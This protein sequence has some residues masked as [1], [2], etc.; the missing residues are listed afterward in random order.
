MAIEEA[1]VIVLERPEQPRALI[2]RPPLEEGRRSTIPIV[3]DRHQRVEARPSR[4][5]PVEVRELQRRRRGRRAAIAVVGREPQQRIEQ[6]IGT[7]EGVVVLG[8][9]RGARTSP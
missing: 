9:R 1:I 6:S 4:H 7:P 5:D 8:L 3:V 2:V